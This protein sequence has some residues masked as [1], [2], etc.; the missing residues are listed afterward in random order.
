MSALGAKQTCAVQSA[1]SALPPKADIYRQHNP[2]SDGQNL[3]NVTV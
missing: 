2:K 3:K 1:M